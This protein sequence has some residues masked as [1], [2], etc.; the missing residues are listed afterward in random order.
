[1]FGW[2]T[3]YIILQETCRLRLLLHLINFVSIKLFIFI[4][5]RCLNI[6]Y[7]STNRQNISGEIF[8]IT[9]FMK[10]VKDKMKF[11]SRETKNIS[12]EISKIKVKSW[13]TLSVYNFPLALCL[14][15]NK[16]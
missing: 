14:K 7:Y 10:F 8:F 11:I 12:G 5:V 4:Y 6:I 9:G 2:R 3:S 15:L 1:M 13:L 16:T